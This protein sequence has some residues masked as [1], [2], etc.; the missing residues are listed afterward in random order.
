MFLHLQ[1]IHRHCRKHK[2]VNVIQEEEKN[3][4]KENILRICF[5]VMRE[6][7]IRFV[8]VYFFNE[9]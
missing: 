5:S 8:S 3:Q 1:A 2:I 4:Q 9:K 7:F 6:H